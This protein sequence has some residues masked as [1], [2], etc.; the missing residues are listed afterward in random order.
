[1]I[2]EEIRVWRR[3]NR[4]V[5]G[6]VAALAVMTLAMIVGGVDGR[7]PGIVVPVPE[8]SELSVPSVTATDIAATGPIALPSTLRQEPVIPSSTR[9]QPTSAPASTAATVPAPAATTSV[10]GPVVNRFDPSA[11]FRI[12]NQVNSLVLDS[13]GRVQ[14]GSAMKLWEPGSPSANLQFQLV[15]TGGG[16]YRMVNRTNGMTVDGR[17]A[18]NAGAYVGQRN[19]DNA[20]EAMQWL[21]SQVSDGVYTLTNR[22]TGLV[23]DGGG[24]GVKFGSL[25][26][27]W[28]VDGSRNL[29]WRIVVV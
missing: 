25:A 13:G 18:R 22:A 26:K 23:L 19:W 4:V 14:P 7:V 15:E 2:T 9:K 3:A 17:G 21:P 8:T 10:Q 5:V 20:S 1:M 24:P 29:L 27:Q 6:V 12:V 28:P 11:S 16:Y